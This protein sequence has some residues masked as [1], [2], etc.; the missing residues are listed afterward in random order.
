MPAIAS[1]KQKSDPSGLI[2]SAFTAAMKIPAEPDPF[3]TNR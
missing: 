3:S 2:K 1:K